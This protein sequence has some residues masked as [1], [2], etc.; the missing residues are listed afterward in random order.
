MGM[1]AAF[2]CNIV[3]GQNDRRVTSVLPRPPWLTW[4]TVS[5]L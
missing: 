5:S 3:L 2:L 4:A 1:L